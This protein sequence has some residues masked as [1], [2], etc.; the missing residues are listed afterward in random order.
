MGPSASRRPARSL[1]SQEGP[2]GQSAK[3]EAETEAASFSATVKMLLLALAVPGRPG[4]GLRSRPG[5]AVTACPLLS[6]PW[7]TPAQKGSIGESKSRLLRVHNSVTLGSGEGRD[8]RELCP[9]LICS[10]GVPGGWTVASLQ[11][12]PGPCGPL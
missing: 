11:A 2:W 4:K 5:L 12:E 8:A 6:G 7:F 3:L 10:P 9:Y 1:G